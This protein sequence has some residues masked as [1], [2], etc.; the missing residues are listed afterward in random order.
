MYQSCDSK[1]IIQ[2]HVGPIFLINI[3]RFLFFFIKMIL[4]GVLTLLLFFKFGHQTPLDDYVF[5]ED[6]HYNYKLIHSYE[7]NGYKLFIFNMTSQ[8]WQDG[9]FTSI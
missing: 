7:L 1:K 5:Q 2:N 8:K 6:P 4:K 9:K 3:S